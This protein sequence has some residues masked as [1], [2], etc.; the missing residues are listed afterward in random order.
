[1]RAAWWW[2]DRWRKSTGYTDLSAEAQG[3]YRNLLDELWLRDGVLP[4]DEKILRKIG[5]D[6]EAWERVRDVV[7]ARFYETADGFRNATHDE[8][9]SRSVLQ[10][11]KGK[12]RAADAARD[13]GK[14]KAESSRRPA[15]QPAEPPAEHQPVEPA[16]DQPPSP[17]PSPFPPPPAREVQGATT[18]SEVDDITDRWNMALSTVL[19]ELQAEAQETGETGQDVLADPMVRE[20]GKAAVVNLAGIPANDRGIR[21][22]EVIADKIRGRRA[23]RHADSRVSVPSSIFDLPAAQDPMGSGQNGAERRVA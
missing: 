1:M 7:M 15:E 6:W 10:A 21:L 16:G 2:V 17:S 3:V 9:A 14:F 18:A 4:K 22:L 23:A 11:E 20:P 12:K 13:G 5:G 8:V 19:T